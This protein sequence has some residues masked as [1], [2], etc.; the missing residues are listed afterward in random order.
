MPILS[1][2]AVASVAARVNS[3]QIVRNNEKNNI[4]IIQGRELHNR[5]KGEQKNMNLLF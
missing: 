3:T 2:V 4:E 5:A 1:V